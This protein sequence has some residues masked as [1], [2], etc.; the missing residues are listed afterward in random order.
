MTAFISRFELL[1]LHNISNG[2]SLVKKMK[3][4]PKFYYAQNFKLKLK[5]IKKFI[6]ILF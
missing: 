3:I 1:E 4:G 5:L 6:I 2:F